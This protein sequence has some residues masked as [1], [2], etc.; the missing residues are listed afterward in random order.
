MSRRSGLLSRN[1]RRAADRARC[2]SL[3]SR[4]GSSKGLTMRGRAVAVCRACCPRTE[5]RRSSLFFLLM[6][7]T[8]AVHSGFSGHYVHGLHITS[9]CCFLVHCT[10]T[11]PLTFVRVSVSDFG[12]LG[13]LPSPFTT[14]SSFLRF[15]EFVH[16]NAP[17]SPVMTCYF[18]CCKN[19]SPLLP[20]L[21][22]LLLD[23]LSVI[24]FISIDSGITDSTVTQSL[25]STPLPPDP[26]SPHTTSVHH[27]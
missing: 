18:F 4:G 17:P 10:L 20:C 22:S 3:I 16:V 7:V 26:L 1:L 2:R 25:S 14:L 21:F 12:F 19:P 6:N 15:L 11:S 24:R 13:S 8:S 9:H 5:P 27:S 23:S